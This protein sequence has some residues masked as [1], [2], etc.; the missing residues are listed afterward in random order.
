MRQVWAVHVLKDAGA[1]FAEAVFGDLGHAEDYASARSEDAGVR[2]TAI[3]RFTV[4]ELGSRSTISWFVDGAS[5]DGRILAA[6]ARKQ[7]GAPG[8]AGQSSG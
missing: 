5:C 7:V 1:T 2:G 6:R 8:W 3:T 4:G